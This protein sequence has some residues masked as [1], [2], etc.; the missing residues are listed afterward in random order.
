MFMLIKGLIVCSWIYITFWFLVFS[1]PVL[2]YCLSSCGFVYFHFLWA[3][4]L[5]ET[6]V[7]VVWWSHIVLVSTYHQRLLLLHLF[8]MIVL[9]GRVS[10]GWSYFHWVPGISHSMPFLFLVSFEK[11]DVILMDLLLYVVFSLLPTSIFFL[12]SLC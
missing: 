8:W 9:L 12:C 10:W 2:W 1:S 7:V 3:E 5:G 11:S 6:F 4:F